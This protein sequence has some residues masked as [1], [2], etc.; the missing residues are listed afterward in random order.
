V[1]GEMMG[2]KTVSIPKSFT[3]LGEKINVIQRAELEPRTNNLG[4]CHY[5]YNEL[6][7]NFNATRKEDIMQ[8]V[9]W[10]EFMHLALDKMGEKELRDDEGFVNILA[11]LIQQAIETM[12]Y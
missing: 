4:E 6:H 9:F 11:G 3:M 2:K 5:R 8:A 12:E 1:K 7:I 10:H